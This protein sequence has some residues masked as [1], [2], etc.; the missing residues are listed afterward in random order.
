M[1]PGVLLGEEIEEEA[2]QIIEDWKD[3]PHIFNL[4]HG[5]WPVHVPEQVCRLIDA[6]HTLSKR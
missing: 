1:D 4:G 3:I 6:V 5:V 2:K